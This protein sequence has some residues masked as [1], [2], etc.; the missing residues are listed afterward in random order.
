MMD[1]RIALNLICG[2]IKVAAIIPSVPLFCMSI[3]L[4]VQAN[5]PKPFLTGFS[6]YLQTDGFPGYHIFENENSE[7]TL[8][9]CMAHAR[10]KFHDAYYP[11]T[12]R[13][14]LA[15]YKWRSVKLLNCMRLKN[16]S[17]RSMLNNVT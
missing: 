16:K 6:G 14:S 12:V 17:N 1:V 15:W 7:V 10:R 11:R 8:L 2:S 13:K 4:L 9:G 5:M 3:S